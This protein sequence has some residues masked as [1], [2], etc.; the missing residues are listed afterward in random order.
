MRAITLSCSSVLL[1]VASTAFAFEAAPTIQW[2]DQ[3]GS[4]G[5]ESAHAV[6][7]DGFGD[8]YLAYYTS[9]SV[10]ATSENDSIF[11]RKYNSAGTLLW[12]E[13]LGQSSFERPI[14]IEVDDAGDLYVA[15]SVYGNGTTWDA[16]LSKYNSSG[17]RYWSQRFG[18]S[19][20]DFG[21]DVCVD[22]QGNA[23][24]SGLTEGVV[25][26]V[27]AGE[28]DAFVAK[29][30]TD[31]NHL[32]SRQ[33]GTSGTD[34]GEGIAADADG[35]VYVTGNSNTGY[36]ITDIDSLVVKYDP[37][38]AL[39]WTREINPAGHYVGSSDIAV[40]D[41]TLYIIGDE[42]LQFGGWD[43]FLATYDT[44]G[45]Y[46]SH[47]RWG[48]TGTPV[49][50]DS[51]S[52]LAVDPAGGLLVIGSTRGDLAAENRGVEDIYVTKF[53]AAGAISWSKQFGTSGSD[54]GNSIAVDGSG[55]IY[56][57]GSTTRAL[58]GSS[59][60]YYD[61][62]LA[63]LSSVPE[64]ATATLAAAACTVL[65]LF[66]RR[67]LRSTRSSFGTSPNASAD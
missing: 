62:Y 67:S 2:I 55:N 44:A 43:A 52:D 4:S 42:Q 39:V 49:A 36:P 53:D 11:L 18:S 65:A 40:V 59:S 19:S 21:F 63:K 33:Y 16:F 45:N 28:G 41:D 48:S 38:G 57:G 64:P 30:D 5:A 37:T 23:F 15:G 58:S 34:F 1:S 26:G 27:N 54:Y 51:T 9:G 22:G 7:V 6:A 12:S 31:G 8:V 35:N 61:A 66:H 3:F 47:F 32:W 56:I 29:F 10:D 25:D 14:S 50:S 46:Q 60:G 17:S 24:V 13:P 20:V